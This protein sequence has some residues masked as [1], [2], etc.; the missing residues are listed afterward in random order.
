[1][2]KIAVCD[3]EKE[4]V[5]RLK[6][7]ILSAGIPAEIDC[8]ESGESLTKSGKNYDIIFLDIDMGGMNGIETAKIIRGKD[9]NVKIIYVTSYAEYVHYAFSVHAFGYLLKP[10]SPDQV[11]EQL[12]EA[13]DY[14]K[15][16]E[17]EDET[18]IRFETKEG[19][20]LVKVRD[21]YYFEYRERRVHMRTKGEELI[22]RGGVR[23]VAER[24]QEYDFAVPHKSFV[25]NLFYVRAVK[26]YDIRM[27]DGSLIPLSQKKST[28]FRTRLNKFLSGCI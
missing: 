1:M 22:I 9:K 26:G 13:S 6:E 7:M 17:K 15:E 10:V 8:Y 16:R 27:M 14:Y 25:V 11:K 28:E 18:R 2:P 20:V 24:M 23:E 3:D 5:I 19:S 21:I 12:Q 4:S